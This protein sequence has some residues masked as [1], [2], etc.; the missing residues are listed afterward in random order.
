MHG[1]YFFFFTRKTHPE[2][3]D[4]LGELRRHLLESS[5]DMAP[6]KVWEM[7]GLNVSFQLLGIR[8]KNK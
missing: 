2:L 4:Q 7:Q 5:T 6:L 1:Y 3:T 8:I